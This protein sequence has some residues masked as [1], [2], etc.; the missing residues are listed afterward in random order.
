MKSISIS[1]G[2]FFVKIV[3]GFILFS[4]GLAILITILALTYGGYSFSQREVVPDNDNSPMPTQEDVKSDMFIEAMKKALKELKSNNED[5]NTK[6]T[7]ETIKEQPKP[8]LHIEAAT[9]IHYCTDE[10]SI[11]IGQQLQSLS[12]EDKNLQIE[13]IRK[14]LAE[15]SS[16]LEWAESLSQFVCKALK[17]NEIIGA[18]KENSKIS[19]LMP[20]IDYHYIQWSKNKQTYIRAIEAR[21]SAF[22]NR[23]IEEQ[24]RIENAHKLGLYSLYIAGACFGLFISLAIYLVILRIDT[25]LRSMSNSL[26]TRLSDN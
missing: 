3:N 7:S 20:L 25:S 18:R 11:S 22:R 15:R 2:D 24:A 12:Q 4:M 19:I 6:I 10:F 9:K 26:E 14:R 21:D 1:T 23:I 8:P 13:V 16:N 5:P 17:N